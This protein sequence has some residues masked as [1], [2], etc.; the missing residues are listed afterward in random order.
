MTVII[1]NH[2]FGSGYGEKLNGNATS[3]KNF[4]DLWRRL[5]LVFKGNPAV[6]GY[7]VMN[8]P[9][10]MPSND[11]W[12]EAAQA[13]LTEIR[14]VDTETPIYV[15]G[16]HWSGAPDWAGNNPKL[17][18]LDDTGCTNAAFPKTSIGCIVWSAHCY[19]DQDNSGTHFN[20]T[21]EAEAGV[22]VHTGTDRLKDFVSWLKAHKFTRAHIG[23][24]GA[25]R[26]NVGWLESLN[27]SMALMDENDWELT[28]E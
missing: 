8:E 12:H 21:A 14:T 1:D 26:D 2:G 5:A 17:H 9:N 10:N 22:T 4:A 24:L 13:V 23:E 28:C 15:E 3:N 25:G 6:A 19:L 20:W 11:S 27:N 18:L 7:D 16:N